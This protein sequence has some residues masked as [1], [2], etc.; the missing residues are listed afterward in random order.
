VL[1]ADEIAALPARP[2][3]SDPGVTNRVLWS[4]ET[5]MA[6]VLH[7]AAGHSLGAH[8]HHANHHH[9]WVL[10]GEALV[11]GETLGAGSYVHI[12]S[13]VDHDIDASSSDGC[14]VFYLY[15]RHD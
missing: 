13:G 11:L 8:A 10:A 14:D 3:G 1:T 7:V 6:G 12:P 2:L 15:I 4:T 9:M 5:S